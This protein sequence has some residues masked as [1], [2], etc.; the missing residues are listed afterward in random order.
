MSDDKA[1]STNPPRPK[2]KFFDAVDGGELLK[3]REQSRLHINERYLLAL[4]KY[5]DQIAAERIKASEYSKEHG[6][7][8]IRT[9]FLLN[10]GAII[11]LLTFV[12]AMFGKTDLNVLLA[13]TLGKKLV[14]AFYC[15]AGGLA[16]A[17]L[18][19][20]LGFFNWRVVADSYAGPGP[21]FDWIH[22]K[23]IEQP[24]NANKLIQG[25]YW[26]AVT[27]VVGSLVAFIAGA[28]LVTTAFSVLGI[29]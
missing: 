13:I 28:Y 18:V 3:I 1:K 23:P 9:V 6:S 21:I 22:N 11:A 15:F 16:A 19:T 25:T 2:A 7:L 14:P 20:G 5:A 26:I 27:I 24:P 17:A 4:E 10:G 29:E 12:S 8:F